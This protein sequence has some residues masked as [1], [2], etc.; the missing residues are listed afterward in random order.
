MQ[1]YLSGT[2]TNKTDNHQVSSSVS[3]H[4]YVLTIQYDLLKNNGNETG[5]SGSIE[6]T[7]A[8]LFLNI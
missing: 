4:K 8:N 2:Y 5:D 1:C 6:K 7:L 3:R